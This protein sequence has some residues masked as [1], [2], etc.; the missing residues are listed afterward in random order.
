MKKALIFCIFFSI[1]LW[2]IHS[3]ARWEMTINNGS[4]FIK[5]QAYPVSAQFP[6]SEA[7]SH[8]EL[9]EQVIDVSFF[10][11]SPNGYQV[12]VHAASQDY[13]RG[14]AFLFKS[15][16]QKGL[17]FEYFF[18][19]SSNKLGNPTPISQKGYCCPGTEGG[20]KVKNG[21]IIFLTNVQDFNVQ[22]VDLYLIITH[23]Q[24]ATCVSGSYLSVIRLELVDF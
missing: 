1:S 10:S 15:E 16:S 5:G 19:C 24:L 18:L 7:D 17:A 6:I 21:S 9:V 8:D 13:A 3:D 22:D 12:S 23:D 20:T 4:N 2:A 11:S 14:D